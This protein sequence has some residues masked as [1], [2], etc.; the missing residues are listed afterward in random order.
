[1]ARN[2]TGTTGQPAVVPQLWKCDPTKSGSVDVCDF[3]EFGVAVPNTTGDKSLTQLN[4]ATRG[5][6]SVLLA[7]SRFLYLGFDDATTGAQLFRTRVASPS[8]ISDFQGQNG[9]AA[10][11]AGCSGLGGAGLGDATTTTRFLDAKAVTAGGKTTVYVL[12]AGASG[13]QRLYA[14]GE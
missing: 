11:T 1:V 7:T 13:A 4:T 6:A 3:G 12:G 10:G 14:I 2:V 5:A 8:A 9:C